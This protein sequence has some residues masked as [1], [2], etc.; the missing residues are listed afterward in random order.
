MLRLPL[1]WNWR[2]VKSRMGQ[3]QRSS[4]ANRLVIRSQ[5][6]ALGVL[7]VTTLIYYPITVSNLREVSD[8]RLRLVT[9]QVAQKLES[10]LEHIVGEAEKLSRLS[11][12][13]NALGNVP[14]SQ[15]TLLP[16]LSEYYLNMREAS[17]PALVDASGR[18][19]IGSLN[20]AELAS[21]TRDTNLPSTPYIGFRSELSVDRL[22]LRFPVYVHTSGS[23]E[24]SLVSSI[25]LKQLLDRV[26]EEADAIER[27]PL[28]IRLRSA[29]G[30]LNL[31]RASVTGSES[32]PVVIP[33]IGNT[34]LTTGLS[35]TIEAS[36][37][38]LLIYRPLV[39]VTG[40]L[41]VF[42]ALVLIVG[43]SM[44][45]RLA[46]RDIEPLRELGQRAME[47]A[48]A[49]AEG[50]RELE[51]VG[52][53][54]IGAMA[55]AFNDMV[56]SLRGVYAHQEERVAERTEALRLAREHLRSVLDGIDDVVYAMRR[57]DRM[58]DYVSASS[59][60]VLGV[61]STDLQQSTDLFF[62]MVLAEDRGRLLEALDGLQAGRINEIRYRIRHA[63]GRVR[64]VLNRMNLILDSDGQL[65]RVGG[66]IRDITEAVEAETML[67]LRE[68]AL[69]SASCGVVITD[70]QKQGQ[71]IIYVND[72]FETITGYSAAEVLGKNCKLLQQN[73]D[74][75]QD[76]LDM[77]R[78]AIRLGESCKVIL[79]NWRKDGEPFWN[80]LQLS[81]LFD[82]H[83]TVTHYIGIQ[84]DITATI[85]S[86]QALVESEQRLTL[87]VDA[88]H[89][90]IWDWSITDDTLVT[91]PSWARVLGLDP[92]RLERRH[93]LATFFDRLSPEWQE[94]LN[95]ALA[96][97]VAGKTDDFYIEHQCQLPDGRVIWAANH[98]RV[99][100]R[101]ENGEPLRMVGSIVD[102]TERMESTERI[103]G[104]MS[105]LDVILTLSPDGIIYFDQDG[106]IF[107]V[108]RAFE[109]MTGIKAG[110]ATGLTRY[111]LDSLLRE[112]AD[113]RYPYPEC[114]FADDCGCSLNTSTA[115]C[116]LYMN[117][118][119]QSVLQI[120]VHEPAEGS[121][122]V[123][124]LHDVTR[125]TEVDRMKSEFLSTAAHELRTPMTSILG[126]VELL[127]MREFNRDAAMRMYDTILR[128]AR[129]LTE[130]INELLD[131]AR[132]E[133]R[134]GN[135]FNMQDIA[136]EDFLREAIE[137]MKVMNG[138][139]GV[140]RL[141]ITI[142]ADL[143]RIYGDP[144]KLQQACM[145]LISNAFKY[146][147]E[148]GAIEVYAGR[149]PK[150]AKAGVTIR[151]RDH[152]I[153]MA[154]ADLA[155]VFERFFRADGSGNIPGTGLGMSLVKEIVSAHQGDILVDSELGSGTMVRIWLP[156]ENAA[157][158]EPVAGAPA[159][160]VASHM[161]EM[162]LWLDS[163][164]TAG[165]V[166]ES[167]REYSEH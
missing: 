66:L 151:I 103:I 133:A 125:E 112:R 56:C 61:D 142:D 90:G 143:P 24:G 129:R 148:G 167:S 135:V 126:Y 94:K 63:D 39:L 86:T 48:K 115:N 85:A 7:L 134:R 97:H 104:L 87:T 102:I 19:V 52:T 118:P 155:R 77:V 8:L 32:T 99:V 59:Q 69:A 149:E 42:L 71:P 18:Q 119:N 49:G 35:L 34:P 95:A 73:G 132:I 23:I 98:G 146:S 4:L 46:A 111:E 100:E 109:R 20:A 58:I 137:A 21:I 138:E 76:T 16:F 12:V 124:Y 17:L 70:M 166:K 27:L 1:L 123:I 121:S 81:P 159:T 160:P 113:H 128:Q 158:G 127:R 74:P 140:A 116:L 130:L 3:W 36:T 67:H 163:E 65:N 44:S 153:G 141:A 51:A 120:S 14:E 2:D 114:F 105:Q 31:Q 40:V 75:E 92:E 89:E 25:D 162:T 154:P 10:E 152:G 13:A 78:E 26:I 55:T 22:Y 161:S 5:L 47:I 136:P 9:G 50:L 93:A 57:D 15:S 82:E 43:V 147:P 144:A 60:R 106:Q 79:R 83:G 145:N 62:S 45:R 117:K 38:S 53:D 54:E 150:D 33:L 64:L 157:A 164:E 139:D 30:A 131:L 80:E 6:I 37:D 29:D 101:G 110:D 88:L 84:N 96:D 107:F 68:R 72:A 41:L 11:L 91:S 156:V 28:N 165:Q 122:I 108:N